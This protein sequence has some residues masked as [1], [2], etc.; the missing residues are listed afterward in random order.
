VHDLSAILH[1]LPFRFGVPLLTTE[2]PSRGD[3][4]CPATARRFP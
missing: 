1:S 2:Y 4:R 3:C